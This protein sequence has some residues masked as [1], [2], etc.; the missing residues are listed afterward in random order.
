LHLGLHPPGASDAEAAIANLTRLIAAV[1]EEALA[2]A[3][4][5]ASAA[6]RW[7]VVTQ[8]AR[9]LEAR[10]LARGGVAVA[11]VVDLNDEKRRRGR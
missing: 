9:E 11:G 7:D 1:V 6:G 2:G 4:A 8:L 5:R 3:L 10:R